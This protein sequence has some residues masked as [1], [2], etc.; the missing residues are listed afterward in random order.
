[1]IAPR[2][3]L[4]PPP[5]RQSSTVKAPAAPRADAA[6]RPESRPGA[7]ERA[8]VEDDDDDTDDG[9]L[10][11]YAGLSRAERKRL[12]RQQRQGRDA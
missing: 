2:T 4:D 8:L 10:D 6:I 11:Q 12:K 5:A 3:D 7:A 1:M 9:P